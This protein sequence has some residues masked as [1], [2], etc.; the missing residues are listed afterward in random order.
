M[1]LRGDYLQAEPM[2]AQALTL[3]RELGD[4]RTEAHIGQEL[5]IVAIHLGDAEQATALLE[6]SLAAFRKWAD[7]L[8]I[9]RCLLGFADLRQVQGETERAAR[10]LGFL[11]LWLRSNKIQLLHFDRTNYEGI[12]AG[13]RTQLGQPRSAASEQAGASFTLEQA[14]ACALQQDEP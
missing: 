5:G 14:V 8:G 12:L 7:P 2:Y 10:L 13:V 4:Q 11:E 3:A 6:G 1:R 9:A